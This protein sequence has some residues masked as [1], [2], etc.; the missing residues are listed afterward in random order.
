MLEDLDRGLLV[1]FPLIS[2]WLLAPAVLLQ[3]A[4]VL[5][6]W[7]SDI[8]CWRVAGVVAMHPGS[9]I[10]IADLPLSLFVNFWVAACT[11]NHF[12]CIG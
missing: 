4:V 6:R 5:H 7:D 11:I 9:E 10:S 2:T 8:V 3:I 1:L 12:I